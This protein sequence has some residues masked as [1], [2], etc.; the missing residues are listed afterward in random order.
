ME[1]K[2]TKTAISEHQFMT[3]LQATKEND[4]EATLQLIQLFKD[5]IQRSSRYIHMPQEDAISSIIVEF[6]AFV[7]KS[8]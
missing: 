8:S 4:D 3:L 1:T 7:K 2:N 5:D 6:L